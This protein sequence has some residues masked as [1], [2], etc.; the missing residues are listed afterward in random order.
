MNWYKRANSNLGQQLMALRPQ[1]ATAAQQVYNN[2]TQ[3]E[4]GY[5]EDLGEGGICQDIADAM[6]GIIGQNI[7]DAEVQIAEAQVGE[8]HV[9]CIVYR[10]YGNPQLFEGYHVDI[11]PRTYE[12]GGG[13]RW[14]KLPDIMFD[15]N[16]VYISKA[17]AD[18][19]APDSY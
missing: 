4:T 16:D 11:P 3:D 14:K 8:Q 15:A 19:I 5:D 13:Y 18:E 6:A 7:P 12:T 10:N 9:W 2:W 17:G 1:L